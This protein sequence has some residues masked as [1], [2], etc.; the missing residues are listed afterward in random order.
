LPALADLPRSIRS[1]LPL[2][3]L[4]DRQ[5]R[6]TVATALHVAIGQIEADKQRAEA[7]ARFK[8]EKVERALLLAKC[9]RDLDGLLYWFDH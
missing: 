3:E 9:T 4:S 7:E 2:P 8:R 1:M 6:Q 5:S